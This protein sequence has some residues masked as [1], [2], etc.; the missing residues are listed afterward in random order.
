MKHFMP[1]NGIYLY[2]RRAGDDTVIVMMNGR[3]EA[4]DVD[5]TRYLEIMPE[6]KKY[7][8][9]LTGEIIEPI[10]AVRKYRFAPREVRVLTPVI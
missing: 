1:T 6:G 7:K 8:D 10:T 2:E 9:I 4:N 5:M 3:D